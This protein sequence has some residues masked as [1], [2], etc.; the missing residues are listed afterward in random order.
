MLS[1]HSRNL[2][3]TLRLIQQNYNTFFY[4]NIVSFVL[5]IYAVYVLHGRLLNYIASNR[6]AVWVIILL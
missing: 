3:K 2:S 4:K 1:V 6:G 5:Y